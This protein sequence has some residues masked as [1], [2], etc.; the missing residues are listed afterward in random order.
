LKKIKELLPFI[1][2]DKQTEHEIDA[3]AIGYTHI[4]NIRKHLEILTL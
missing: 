1:K 3:I 2:E 4:I